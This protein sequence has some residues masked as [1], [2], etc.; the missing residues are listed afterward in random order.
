MKR[1]GSG[2]DNER[3]LDLA[4]LVDGLCDL[5]VLAVELKM[6]TS[7]AL[8]RMAILDVR[9]ATVSGECLMGGWTPPSRTLAGRQSF[10]TER[11]IDRSLAQSPADL[12][13]PYTQRKSP[14]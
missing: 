4:T 9:Q 1:Q 3:R 5:Q 10:S 12:R 7:D 8:L 6:E 13:V 11:G 14:A 2:A